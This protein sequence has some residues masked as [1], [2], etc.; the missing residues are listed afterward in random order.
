M[1]QVIWACTVDGQRDRAGGFVRGSLG[2]QA[3]WALC[4]SGNRRKQTG[5]NGGMKFSFNAG[6]GK[7]YPFWGNVLEAAADLYF[8]ITVIVRQ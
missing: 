8:V 6:R 4:Y 5:H 3:W 1:L 7:T 2:T